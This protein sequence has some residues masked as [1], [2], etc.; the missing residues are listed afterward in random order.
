MDKESGHSDVPTAHTSDVVV[1]IESSFGPELKN[2]ETSGTLFQRR[3]PP[4]CVWNLIL[5]RACTSAL[6]NAREHV[7]LYV[8]ACA[9]ESAYILD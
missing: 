6:P 1:G 7:A 4:I 5:E 3:Y 9:R 8:C 2:V